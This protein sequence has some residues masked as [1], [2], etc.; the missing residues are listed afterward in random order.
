MDECKELLTAIVLQA[1]EDW[2]KLCEGALPTRDCSFTE[3]D[4]F[5]QG[6]CCGYISQDLAKKIYNELKAERRKAEKGPVNIAKLFKVWA[7]TKG[8]TVMVWHRSGEKMLDIATK[9][10][11]KSHL[12]KL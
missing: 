4:E 5:F 8:N 9:R 2:R 11:L 1:V 10:C 6:G 7:M 3:L 12:D